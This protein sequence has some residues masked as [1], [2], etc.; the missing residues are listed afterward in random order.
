MGPPEESSWAAPRHLRVSR[1]GPEAPCHLLPRTRGGCRFGWSR[2]VDRCIAERCRGGSR[3]GARPE[4]GPAPGVRILARVRS[5]PVGDTTPYHTLCSVLVVGF[6]LTVE[7]QVLVVGS[8]EWKVR[9]S[10]SAVKVHVVR[11]RVQGV[12]RRVLGEELLVNSAWAP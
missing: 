11:F 1:G 12:G 5:A 4:R 9:R 10:V 7:C 2:L 6:G 3:A 8:G